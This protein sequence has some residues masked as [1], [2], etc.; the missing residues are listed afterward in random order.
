MLS[1]SC[2]LVKVTVYC[3]MECS[4]RGRRLHNSSMPYMAVGRLGDMYGAGVC[5]W[6]VGGAAVAVLRGGRL[7]AGVRSPE[8]PR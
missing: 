5:P 3:A 1:A 8:S 2:V 6:R 7:R 4:Q